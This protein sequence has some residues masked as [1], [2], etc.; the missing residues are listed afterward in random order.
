MSAVFRT[1]SIGDKQPVAKKP[2]RPAAKKA[3]VKRISKKPPPAVARKK[4]AARKARS[5]RIAAS[6]VKGEKVA[7]IARDLG[8]SR[9]WASHEAHSPETQALIASMV[10]QRMPRMLQ[11]LDKSLDAV[12]DSLKA[13][14]QVL[15][16]G[17]LTNAGADHFARLTG[18]K[19]FIELALAGRS[20]AK[21]EERRA[22]GPFTLQDIEQAMTAAKS[23]NA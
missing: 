4:P 6:L 16:R 7:A 11:L 10:D 1:A 15:I 12:L 21:P 14:K 17:K 19:R 13:M 2:V 23:A 8:L 22:S 18:V 20:I 5:Q 3:P 9:T